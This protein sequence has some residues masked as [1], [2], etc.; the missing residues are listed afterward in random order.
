MQAIDIMERDIVSV[1]SGTSLIAATRLL[2]DNG[3]NA[4]PV[5]RAD[6]R[7]IG[8]IGIRDV[9]RVPIPSHSD[10]PILLWDS[11]EEKVRQLGALTVDEVMTRR[12]LVSVSPQASI[13]EVASIMANRGVHPLLVLHEG[14]LLGVIGRADVARALL[15][16]SLLEEDGDTVAADH[17]A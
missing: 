5:R 8:M 13:V 3:I 12:Q 16:L 10:M 6:G 14:E 9:L 15:N 7:V 11:L 1:S 2:L 4:M 17:Q